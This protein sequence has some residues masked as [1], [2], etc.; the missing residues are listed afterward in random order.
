MIAVVGCGLWGTNILRTLSEMRVLEAICDE[1][2]T[3]S[4]NRSQCFQVPA[5]TFPQILENDRIQGVV[6]SIP[7]PLHA[8]MALLVLSSGKHVWIEKPMALNLQDA[9]NI[10][11]LADENNLQVLVG[12]VI[13]YHGAFEKMVT[14]IHA[15]EIGE[16]LYIDCIRNNW[17][18]VCPWEK[19]ALWSL[20]VHDIS[21]VLSLM[22]Q[23]PVK[24]LRYVQ[25]CVQ[26]GD[27]GMLLLKFKNG[28]HARIFSSWC[29]PIKEQRCVVVGSQGSLVFDD[30][31]PDGQE[32][33]LLRHDILKNPPFLSSQ[34][35]LILEY[36]YH[37][38]PLRRQCEAFVKAIS[39]GT[40]VLTP[41]QEALW[42]IEILTTAQE[43]MF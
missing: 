6:L 4:S 39:T 22:A 15:Q 43:I 3:C 18:R 10:C 20:G 1:D 8:K 13:R 23:R 2:S 27:Q 28:V 29:Y 19:D 25:S 38:L 16:I 12:H 36:D 40:P 21:L 35:S 42:G 24:A 34:T 14:L 9:K 41:G 33:R 31:N 5:L 7:A 32:L 30:M 17:G 37:T 26:G 11:A